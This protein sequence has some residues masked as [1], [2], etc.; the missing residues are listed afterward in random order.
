MKLEFN[1]TRKNDM[2]HHSKVYF[3]EQYRGNIF[4]L[5]NKKTELF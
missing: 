4:T 3:S 1:Q 5:L 2:P